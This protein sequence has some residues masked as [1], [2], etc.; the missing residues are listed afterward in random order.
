MIVFCMFLDIVDAGTLTGM[1]RVERKHYPDGSLQ[2]EAHYRGTREHGPWRNWHPNGQLAAE[3]WFEEGI[4]EGTNRTWDEHGRLTSEVNI[5]NGAALRSVIWT[6]RGRILHAAYANKRGSYSL[7][8]YAELCVKDPSLP[9]YPELVPAIAA[10]EKRLKDRPIRP[11]KLIIALGLADPNEHD[12]AE[13]GQLLGGRHVEALAWLSEEQSAG[14]NLGE[15]NVD[16]SIALVERFY[17][18]GAERV[19]AVSLDLVLGEDP[20]STND[21]LV[22]LPHTPG[23][24]AALFKTVRLI[25]EKQGFEGETDRGQRFLFLRLC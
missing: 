19:E 1:D 4:Y 5:V 12:G 10:A 20:G 22:Q 23:K 13:V 16:E 3:Y 6:S 11:R 8:G 14:R 15:L 25:V 7:K 9:R 2:E 24:R 18:R 21:L 17:R